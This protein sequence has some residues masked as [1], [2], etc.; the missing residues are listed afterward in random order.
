M[1]E[2]VTSRNGMENET[3][4]IPVTARHE[5]ANREVLIAIVLVIAQ[6]PIGQY[7]DKFITTFPSNML[8]YTKAISQSEG[9]GEEEEEE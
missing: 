6:F 4:V 1:E 3:V 2:I 9:E 7:V 8:S 5:V